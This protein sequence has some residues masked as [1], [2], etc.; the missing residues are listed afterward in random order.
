[1]IESFRNVIGSIQLL[2][3]KEASRL[4]LIVRTQLDS[5]GL[6]ELGHPSGT[7]CFV[8]PVPCDAGISSLLCA[9]T[10]QCGNFCIPSV[11]YLDSREPRVMAHTLS[12]P[13]H[14]T[15]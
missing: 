12:V 5:I 2:M 1:M 7:C 9:S 4:L 10:P 6:L 14:T 15:V 3:A 11:L 13:K 8:V